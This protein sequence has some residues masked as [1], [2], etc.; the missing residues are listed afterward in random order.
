MREI[1]FRGKRIDN[2]EWVEGHF[3]TQVYTPETIEEEWYWFIKPIG[4]KSWENFRVD[5]KTVGQYTGLHDKN[6]KSIFEGDVIRCWHHR[7]GKED[8]VTEEK[9]VFHQ[10]A[11]VAHGTNGTAKWW[12]HL[13][14][15]NGCK[16]LDKVYIREVEIIGNMHD[17]AP[18]C[19]FCDADTYEFDNCISRDIIILGERIDDLKQRM[20]ADE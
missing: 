7:A 14:N 17:D 9:V 4:G 10:G 18:L 20:E 8:L 2:G 19:P 5:P 3:Y 6:G 15:D 16:P 11:F 1:I 12:G 13:P